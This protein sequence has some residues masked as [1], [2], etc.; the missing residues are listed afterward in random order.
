MEFHSDDET[1]SDGFLME[2]TEYRVLTSCLCHQCDD[3]Q[4]PIYE[5]I[6]K[7]SWETRKI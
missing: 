7:I 6:A 4:I 2:E 5:I 3:Y 1:K